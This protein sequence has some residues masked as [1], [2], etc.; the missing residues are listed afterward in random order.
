[1]AKANWCVG[2]EEVSAAAQQVEVCLLTLGQG[3]VTWRPPETSEAHRSSRTPASPPLHPDGGPSRS[4]RPRTL[5]APMGCPRQVLPR[6][7]A[8]LSPA[9]RLQ[10]EVNACR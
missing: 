7:A 8:S 5:T 2:A 1:M 6:Q 3:A 10:I 4:H 9:I